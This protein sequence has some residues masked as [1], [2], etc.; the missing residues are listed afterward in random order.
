MRFD[1][2]RFVSDP[3]NLAAVRA[4]P[5][6]EL[7][8]QF[9]LDRGDNEMK[10]GRIEWEWLRKLRIAKGRYTPEQLA[11]G[12]Q[13]HFTGN[14]TQAVKVADWFDIPWSGRVTSIRHRRCDSIAA[15]SVA[16]PGQ[17]WWA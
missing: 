15:N 10:T 14:R 2:A 13:P 5:L 4:R 1:A 17:S 6:R 3:K 7:N 12:G 9:D 11:T 8:P 16:M